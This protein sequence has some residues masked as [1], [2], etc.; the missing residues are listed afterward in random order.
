[1][2]SWF[3]KPDTSNFQKFGEK[4]RQLEQSYPNGLDYVPKTYEGSI[5]HLEA[6]NITSCKCKSHDR[7]NHF[8]CGICTLIVLNPKECHHCNSLFC[9]D[10]LDEWTANNDHCPKNCNGTTGL[11]A[12]TFKQINRYVQFDLQNIEFKCKFKACGYKGLYEDALNHTIC[13][14]F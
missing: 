5:T 7:T 13:C 11:D 9:S 14:K 1:M 3:A 2:G 10:C 12:V 8:V 6:A 4:R